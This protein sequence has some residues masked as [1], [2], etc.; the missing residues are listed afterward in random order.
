MTAMLQSSGS[1][2]WKTCMKAADGK[3]D[4]AH[5]HDFYTVLLVQHAVGKHIIDFNE[6]DFSDKQVH[7]VSPGQVHQVIEK[8]K[9]FGF[10]LLFSDQFLVN[11][12][13]P[14]NFIEDLNLFNSYGEAPPIEIDEKTFIELKGLCEEIWK[15]NDAIREIRGT[16]HRFHIKTVSHS[17]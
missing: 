11:N 14:L 7:F 12:H 6:Y 3:T 1:R 2:G 5:R 9:S 10:V 13:I 4:D 16:C 8:E 15:W 17:V